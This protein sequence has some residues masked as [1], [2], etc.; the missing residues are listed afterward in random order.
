MRRVA[1]ALGVLVLAAPARAPRRPRRTS[2]IVPVSASEP[3]GD[4]VFL[5]SGPG[6]GVT[7]REE[8]AQGDRRPRAAP[9]LARVLRPAVGLP[10]RR[11][12]VARA[13]RG[14]RP[15]QRD[16]RVAFR[17]QEALMPFLIDAAIRQINRHKRLDFAILTGD[18]ADNQQRNETRVGPH[19]ARRRPA[20]PQQRR[21]RGAG[22]MGVDAAEARALHGGAGLRRLHRRSAI[23]TTPTSPPACS[24]SG[25]AYPGLM[26]RA[27]LPFDGRRPRRP[28]LRRPRQPR[29]ARAGQPG[30]QR[31][32]RRARAQGC[33]KADGLR[34]TAARCRVADPDATPTARR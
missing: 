17:P 9:P 15:D 16:L 34:P 29:R 22:C 2:G 25:R 13:R 19:A 23:S 12:G 7:V 5:T 31:R 32:D 24:R 6:E 11:R 30:G 18:N 3:G 33:T 28:V 27:Q 10:A 26:D 20:R 21:R 1:L 4:F 8:L 14:A